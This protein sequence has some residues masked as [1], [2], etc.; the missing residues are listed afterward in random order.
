MRSCDGATPSLSKHWLRSARSAIK[1]SQQLP[2]QLE[3]SS[4]VPGSTVPRRQKVKLFDDI[5]D[6]LSD[7]A[8]S[9]TNA[10]LKTKVLIHKIGHKEVAAWLTDELD[11]YS[12]EKAIP[13]Y[14]VI[15]VR[16]VGNL[17]N[18]AYVYSNQTLPA[19]HLSKKLQEEFSRDELRQS[20]HDSK[21]SRRGLTGIWDLKDEVWLNPEGMHPEELKQ[22]A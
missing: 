11:G 22:F 21:N 2:D 10:M 5:V 9:L 15:P 18:I 14:R 8:S 12:K 7:K 13:D 3:L 17:Q 20:I 4:G 6:L 1:Y 16:L 19:A